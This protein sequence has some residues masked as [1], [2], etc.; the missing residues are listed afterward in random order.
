M[1]IHTVAV[2]GSTVWQVIDKDQAVATF[3]TLDGYTRQNAEAED[4]T[5]RF[6]KHGILGPLGWRFTEQRTRILAVPDHDPRD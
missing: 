3:S 6:A 4:I 1:S 2:T 5:R